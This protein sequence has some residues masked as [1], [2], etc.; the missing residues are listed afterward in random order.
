[1]ISVHF[2][3]IWLKIFIVGGSG[4]YTRNTVNNRIN[5][6]KKKGILLLKYSN[7][8]WHTTFTF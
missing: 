8:N 1:M 2:D 6:L 3:G 7:Q 4:L 5:S